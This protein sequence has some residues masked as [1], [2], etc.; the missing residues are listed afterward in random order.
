MIAPYGDDRRMAPFIE[1]GQRAAACT[2]SPRRR[3][4]SH[5]ASSMSSTSLRAIGVPV[6]TAT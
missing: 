1:P 2:L 3:S 4:T 6:A 5:A